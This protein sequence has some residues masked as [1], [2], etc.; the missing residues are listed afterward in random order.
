MDISA[1]LFLA[2]EWVFRPPDLPGEMP[3]EEAT[4]L[5]GHIRIAVLFTEVFAGGKFVIKIT[6]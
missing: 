4:V 2:H 5:T 3:A 6:K 1:L